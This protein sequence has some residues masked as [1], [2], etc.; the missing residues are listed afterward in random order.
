MS[1]FFVE[2]DYENSIIELF[3]ND[4]GYEYAYG[5]DIERDFYSPLYEDVLVESLYRLNRGVPDSRRIGRHQPMLLQG[6]LDAPGMTGV[7]E[8]VT[9]A[10]QRLDDEAPARPCLRLGILAVEGG[11]LRRNRAGTTGQ[12]AHPQ[13]GGQQHGTAAMPGA[14]AP[15]FRLCPGRRGI[16]RCH[17]HSRCGP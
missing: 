13:Q 6:G 8:A 5:P 1:N 10:R 4:L 16:L 17:D 14:G 15:G 9:L 3:Q 11:D 7:F 12:N 2:A